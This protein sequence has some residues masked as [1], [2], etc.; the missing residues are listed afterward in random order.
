MWNRIAQGIA[1]LCVVRGKS[2]CYRN[3]E[4]KE[5]RIEVKGSQ[6]TRFCLVKGKAQCPHQGGVPHQ[7]KAQP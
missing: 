5:G 7:E 1:E 2:L 6:F 3:R 4:D